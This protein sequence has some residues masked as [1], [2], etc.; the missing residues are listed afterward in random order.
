M[1]EALKN[2]ENIEP[3]EVSTEEPSPTKRTRIATTSRCVV[4]D[5][6]K[7]ELKWA[8]LHLSPSLLLASH[9]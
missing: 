3:C 2:M 6:Y 7:G 8:Q 1:A 9:V 5:K 4:L